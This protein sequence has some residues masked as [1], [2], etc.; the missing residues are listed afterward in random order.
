[1][2]VYVWDAASRLRN[3]SI[4]HEEKV[5]ERVRKGTD[6]IK[7]TKNMRIATVPY[8]LHLLEYVLRWDRT[9]LTPFP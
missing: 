1:M 3:E 7:E 6:E 2:T 8:V 5:S 9:K 4:K